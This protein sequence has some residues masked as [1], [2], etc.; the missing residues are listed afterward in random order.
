MCGRKSIKQRGMEEAP[1]NSKE[2]LHSANAN[3]MN[4]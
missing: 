2:F 4:E 1:E 3:G